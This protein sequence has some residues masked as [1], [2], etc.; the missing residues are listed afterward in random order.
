MLKEYLK[1]R[2]TPICLLAVVLGCANPSVE[3]RTRVRVSIDGIEVE[4]EQ[5]PVNP[6]QPEPEDD[7]PPPPPP[8]P[9][10]EL[11]P[12]PPGTPELMVAK[13]IENDQ[14][15]DED[16]VVVPARVTYWAFADG[17]TED[18]Y[19]SSGWPIS[20]TMT[21]W[22]NHEIIE[23]SVSGATVEVFPH[24]D[25]PE[26]W[27]VVQVVGRYRPVF[28]YLRDKVGVVSAAYTAP[29]ETEWFFDEDYMWDNSLLP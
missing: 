11:N 2:M 6:Q 26:D 28:V 10:P 19:W 23:G 13:S 5:R 15:S 8:P 9:P 1:W 27:K 20:I 29:D 22:A 16:L 17:S 21:V 14:R 25:A 12:P 4:H 18:G 24:P 7:P 3:S